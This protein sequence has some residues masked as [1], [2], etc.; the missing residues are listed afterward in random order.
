M[1]ERGEE[2]SQTQWK[3]QDRKIWDAIEQAWS[4]AI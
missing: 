2:K 1:V 4:D 3:V